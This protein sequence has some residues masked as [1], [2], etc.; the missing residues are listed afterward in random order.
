MRDALSL[1]GVHFDE[2]M[3]RKEIKAEMQIAM[4]AVDAVRTNNLHFDYSCMFCSFLFVLL[5]ILLYAT[6]YKGC[7]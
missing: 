2:S 3:V 5:I 1:H 6:L 4:H 7:Q